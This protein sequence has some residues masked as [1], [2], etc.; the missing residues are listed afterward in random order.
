MGEDLERVHPPKIG[1]TL[2]HDAYIHALHSIAKSLKRIA[3]SLEK[4]ARQ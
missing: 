3:D 2:P 1:G 4:G